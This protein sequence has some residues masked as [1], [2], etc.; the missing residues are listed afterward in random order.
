[1]TPNY[2]ILPYRSNLRETEPLKITLLLHKDLFSSLLTVLFYFAAIT[3]GPPVI[4]EI[5]Q[6]HVEFAL[7]H[8]EDYRLPRPL[9]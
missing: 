7:R 9:N 2:I 1:M 4:V 5:P 8:L 6:I 3:E